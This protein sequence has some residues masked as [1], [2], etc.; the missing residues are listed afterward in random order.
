MKK[1]VFFLLAGFLAVLLGGC[2]QAPKE[3]D[4]L[5]LVREKG[6]YGYIDRTGRVIIP[7]KFKEAGN[8]SDG[9]ARVRLNEAEQRYGYIDTSGRVVIPPQFDQ[10][11]DFFEGWLGF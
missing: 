1:L 9:L 8:F 6:K 2:T 7:P 10:V 5:F 11:G 4:R 3:P